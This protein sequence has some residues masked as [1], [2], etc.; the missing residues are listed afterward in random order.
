MD[1]LR[2]VLKAM[3]N[4]LKLRLTTGGCEEDNSLP[5]EDFQF[6]GA[7]TTPRFYNGKWQLRIFMS[8]EFL[9]PLLRNDL[10]PAER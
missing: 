3:A 6:A 8:T 10:T 2:E 9:Q 4:H 1:R 5:R 7:T